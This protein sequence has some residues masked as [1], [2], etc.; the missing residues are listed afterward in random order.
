MTTKYRVLGHR[1]SKYHVAA[2]EVDGR[3][4]FEEFLENAIETSADEVK[5]V[6]SLLTWIADKG[7]PSE[8]SEL[9]RLA[10]D[11]RSGDLFVFTIGGIRVFWFIYT[12]YI[13]VCSVT[14]FT[15]QENYDME[16]EHALMLKNGCE[17]VRYGIFG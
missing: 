1:G 13:I 8:K 12:R 10:D 9:C 6:V 16:V 5:R 11:E 17:V 4:Q 7:V 3:C 2:C 15:T 14:I